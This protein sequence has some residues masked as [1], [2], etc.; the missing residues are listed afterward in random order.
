M[1]HICLS[2]FM[3]LILA[4]CVK[5]GPFKVPPF[6]SFE[7]T[8]NAYSSDLPMPIQGV[9]TQRDGSLKFV[10][11]ARQGVVL[12]YGT[13]NPA[14][15]STDIAFSQS[16]G[17]RKLLEMAADALIELMKLVN[18]GKTTSEHWIIMDNGK[19][20]TYKGPHLEL[21]GHLRDAR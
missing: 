16:S 3:A 2:L 20:M 13:I 4:A 14:D 19:K 10:V 12:G 17:T 5:N 21:N 18:E 9:L 7:F 6:A 15:G 8:G 11:A 1:K